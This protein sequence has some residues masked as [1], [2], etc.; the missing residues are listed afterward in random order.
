MNGQHD[1]PFYS[2]LLRGNIEQR[3]LIYPILF[4]VSLKSYLSPGCLVFVVVPKFPIAVSKGVIATK[5]Y[6]AR[7]VS[8]KL[9]WEFIMQTTFWA[10]VRQMYCVGMS[11]RAVH[12]ENP[13][14][15]HRLWC[16][17][18]QESAR[19]EHK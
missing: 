13:N 4:A 11:I 2:E 16:C 3:N 1:W 5:I 9:L 10:A 12:K 18:D 6:K 19:S 14:T 17:V 15:I 8:S 7:L